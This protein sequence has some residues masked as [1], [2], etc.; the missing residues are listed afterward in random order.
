MDKLS[1]II[2]SFATLDEFV[3]LA[4]EYAKNSDNFEMINPDYYNM[5]YVRLEKNGVRGVAFGI[6]EK[7]KITLTHVVK[8]CVDRANNECFSFYR[9]K[10]GITDE[11]LAKLIEKER[12]KYRRGL[13][14]EI[15]LTE[16]ELKGQR[17]ISHSPKKEE[18]KVISLQ[19]Y[20]LKKG[21]R[22]PYKLEPSFFRKNR[23]GTYTEGIVIFDKTSN[24]LVEIKENLENFLVKNRNNV[25]MVLVSLGLATTALGGLSYI[26]SR[27]YGVISETGKKMASTI[28]EASI[29][30]KEDY[31]EYLSRINK[32]YLY[33]DDNINYYITETFNTINMYKKIL[34]TENTRRINELKELIDKQ[35]IGVKYVIS[36]RINALQNQDIK[37]EIEIEYTNLIYYN[38]ALCNPKNIDSGFYIK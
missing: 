24:R 34:D 1:F 35:I 23:N 10:D 14:Q 31:L 17:V 6:K 38:D 4:K 28:E 30:Q 36:S 3:E 27:R 21:A 5:A 13:E 11:Y 20:K 8:Y 9:D 37:D 2:D 12:E 29:E 19:Q 33:D 15:A 18:N 26:T 22:V 32:E 16:G 25:I 7:N